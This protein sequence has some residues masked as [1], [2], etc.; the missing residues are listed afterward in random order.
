MRNHLP[1]KT[2]YKHIA[3]WCATKNNM[4]KEVRKI[5]SFRCLPSIMS[6]YDKK[7]EKT[8]SAELEALIL[9]DLTEKRK[10]HENKSIKY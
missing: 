9:K 8:R 7:I 10:I 1:V 5:Y 4:K 2:K 3:Q 6:K